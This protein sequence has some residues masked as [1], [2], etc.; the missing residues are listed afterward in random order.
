MDDIY[1][2]PVYFNCGEVL[3]QTQKRKITTYFQ[4]KRKSGGGECSPVEEVSGN[5]YKT[6]F[7]QREDQQSVLQRTQHVVQLMEGR[8]TLTVKESLDPQSS[9]HTSTSTTSTFSSSS[10]SSTRPAQTP[11]VI[12]PSPPP[13][14][15]EDYELHPDGSLRESLQASACSAPFD[16]AEQVSVKSPAVEEVDSLLESFSS[17]QARD[18]FSQLNST[19]EEVE[20]RSSLRDSLASGNRTLTTNSPSSGAEIQME[21]AAQIPAGR[22][23]RGGGIHVEIIQGTI[24]TQQVDAL[25]SPMI[26]YN[27]QTTGIGNTLHQRVGPQL[28]AAFKAAAGSEVM[29]GFPVLV[30]NLPGLPSHAVFFLSLCPWNGDPDGAAVEVLK[31]G[32]DSILTTC[33]SRG[34]GSVVFPALGAGLMLSFP[35]AVVAKVL[36]EG[37]YTFQ[38]QRTSSRPLTVRIVIHPDDHVSSEV[39]ICAEEEIH[40]NQV[41]GCAEPPFTPTAKLS[42]SKRIVLL[43][44]TGSGKSSLANIILGENL[45]TVHH[46]SVSGTSTCQSETRDISD[47]KITLV[48]T[49]G[50][51]DTERSEE[52]LNRE[53]MKCITECAPGIHGFL[54][55]LRVER[56]SEQEQAVI[57]RICEYFSE[58]ALKH[59]VVVFTFGNE[60]PEGMKIEKFIRENQKLSDL[61][62]RCGGRCH[63]FDNKHWNNNT[64]QNDYRSNRFQREELLKT[65]DKLTVERNGQCYTNDTLQAVEGEIQTVEEQIRQSSPEDLPP[66]EIR[67]QARR[68]VANRFLI[69]LA[70]VTTGIL[71]GALF[72]V[73]VLVRAVATVVTHPSQAINLMK[74][75]PALMGAPAAAVAGGEAALAV[76]VGAGVTAAAVAATGGVLG[77]I[78]GHE[79]AQGAETAQDAVERA[80]KAV[81][82]QRKSLRRP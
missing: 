20:G 46:S 61:V 17:R 66:E 3:S 23:T 58:D 7:R 26:G 13:P 76:G 78:I 6:A 73:E 33:D 25:V 41:Q 53:I 2:F 65:I 45:F 28:K 22:T 67:N 69:E 77:G 75:V 70:G 14:S 38:Q 42:E 9:G 49:P 56:F 40:R 16:P 11:Q 15:G 52:D 35:I 71:L 12:P 21:A 30:E 72:G 60:L 80:A 50:L 79:A 47:R 1:R 24:E 63:V 34:F 36:L 68:Q 51:F 48:D 82:G 5:T 62:N 44:K 8:L 29:L 81:I 64:L 74:K 55:V 18:E 43:G 37:I 54:I 4:V 32:I 39:F 10:T 27:L 19:V 57:S 31:M 59:A